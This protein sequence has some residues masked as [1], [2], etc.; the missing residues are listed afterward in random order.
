MVNNTKNYVDF[1]SLLK[2]LDNLKR[3]SRYKKLEK[4]ASDKWRLDDVVYPHSGMSF[5]S[6][7]YY[8]LSRS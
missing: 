4:A 7:N 6:K 8:S 2:L 3:E 5:N 1:K